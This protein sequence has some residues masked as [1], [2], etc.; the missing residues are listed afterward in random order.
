MNDQTGD[1]DHQAGFL[2]ASQQSHWPDN[3]QDIVERLPED[4]LE[5]TA[6][7]LRV[8][9]AN[10]TR[11]PQ[12]V[13]VS[14]EGKES[15]GGDPYHFI[16]APFHFCLACGVA[17][18]GRQQSDYGKLAVLS[19]EGRSTATT[20]LSIATLQSL[21]QDSDLDKDCLLYT[22]RCV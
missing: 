15:A 9:K 17:Y 1:K 3:E 16:K 7:G 12:A 20:I 18:S 4:W 6:S 5:N 10:R 2:Y 21:R 13:I 11:L 14:T 19:S 8:K 22:S